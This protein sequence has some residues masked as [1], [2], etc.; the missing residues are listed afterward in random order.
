MRR[1]GAVE[2]CS[3]PHQCLREEW[4]LQH[5][6]SPESRRMTCSDGGREGRR[7]EGGRERERRKVGGGGERERERKRGEG[8]RERE[9]EKRRKIRK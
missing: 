7:E 3:K 4:C 5:T 6:D 9:S 1:V 2:P 8:A